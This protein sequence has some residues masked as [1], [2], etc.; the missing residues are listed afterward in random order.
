[1]EAAVVVAP[2]V[3][4]PVERA[5]LAEARNAEYDRLDGSINDIL[6]GLDELNAARECYREA[7]EYYDG[8]LGV[9]FA[10]T[11][12][13]RLLNRSGVNDVEDFAYARI[14]VD[15]IANRLQ[16]AA[17]VA[18]KAE[19]DADDETAPEEDA[20]IKAAEKAIAA[21]R[22]RNQLDDEEQYLHHLVS[23]HGDAYLLVWPVYGDD[24]EVVDVDMRVNS[25][26]NVRMVFDEEDTLVPR[27]VIKSWEVDQ[28]RKA[29][30]A[31]ANRRKIVR[32]NLYYPDRIERW[33]TDPGAVVDNPSAWHKLVDA[34]DDV[35]VAEAADDG[36]DTDGDD[37]PNPWGVIPWF[38]FRN[39]RPH[40][41]PEH[42]GAYGP[43]QM[44][45]KLVSADGAA[46]DFQSFPQRYLLVDPMADDPLM[47]IDDPDHPDDEE[48]DPE[49]ETGNAG[50]DGSPG[51]IWKLYGKTVGQFE[52]AAAET[53]LVRLDRYVK[54]M[55]ELTDTPQHAFSKASA[56]M[57]SGEA[58]RE[59]NG[60]MYAKVR[61]RQRR[62]DPVWQDAYELA[63]RMLGI[64]EVSVDVR[65][66]PIEVVNDSAGWGV[67]KQKTEAG[68]PN[69]IALE[70]AGYAAEQVEEWLND[71]TGADMQRRV[72]VLNQIATAAQAMGAAVQLG[73]VADTTAKELFDRFLR[74]TAEG[75]A[76]PE[77]TP[78]SLSAPKFRDPPP[79]DPAAAAAQAAQK[80]PAP[81]P[82]LAVDPNTNKVPENPA[83]VALKMGVAKKA[84]PNGRK[85]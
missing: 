40:G 61:N 63:L 37:I 72:A 74:L 16:I 18:A 54:S 69:Q 11:R 45:N 5:R 42:K 77:K 24:G 34:D 58:V 7:D 1:L 59:L 10:S 25:A 71:L 60:P 21:L 44:I 23:K 15:V 2:Y 83:M 57:P 62:Y 75:T 50:L 64:E 41:T 49:T 17:V 19:E 8:E 43:Q 26:H 81:P 39:N 47:N 85:T 4:D 46:V 65:W 12:I 29:K 9:P 13:A 79:S 51:S 48:D 6:N 76:D 53:F 20:R 3:A 35:D 14:P 70:E 27:Y 73:V 31:T 33:I 55:A 36:L 80:F 66:E 56:D 78:D 38:Y 68:V 30:E 28:G 84:Q 67:L 82:K 22:K 32:A 52:V